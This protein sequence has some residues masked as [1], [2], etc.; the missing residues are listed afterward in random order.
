MALAKYK[1]AQRSTGRVSVLEQRT[2]THPTLLDL[3]PTALEWL[4]YGEQALSR[5]S[6]S[7]FESHLI[8]WVSA[9]RAEILAHLGDLDDFQEA[10][11]EAGLENFQVSVF[12]R[13]LTRLFQ[14]LP[15]AP[16]P[17]PDYRDYREDGNLLLLKNRRN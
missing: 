16:P 7:G 9:Q 17:L 4:G 3:A 8:R 15:E 2:E 13:R 11:N 6:R 14:F 1:T 12:R 10:L 5:F